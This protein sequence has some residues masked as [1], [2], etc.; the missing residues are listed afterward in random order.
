MKVPH[1]H[2]QILQPPDRQRGL[3]AS[4]AK[5]QPAEPQCN[6]QHFRGC[7]RMLK[8]MA[9]CKTFSKMTQERLSA[10]FS[11]AI[12]GLRVCLNVNHAHERI[13]CLLG[14]FAVIV[15]CMHSIRFQHSIHNAVG[16]QL[17][18]QALFCTWRPAG[19]RLLGQAGRPNC[20]T[21]RLTCR[22]L[23]L[24]RRQVGSPLH[25]VQRVAVLY[26]CISVTGKSSTSQ[27]S[28]L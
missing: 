14:A 17:V 27:P 6:G 8:A 5:L 26:A 16:R 9:Q 13:H 1:R 24:W 20:S 3:S 12:D 21:V 25:Q 22:L 11:E 15:P 10:Y 18:L 28:R 19:G 23:G 2:L 4:A 7:N